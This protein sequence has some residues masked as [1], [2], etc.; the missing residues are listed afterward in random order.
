MYSIHLKNTNFFFELRLRYEGGG[1]DNWN[2]AWKMVKVLGQQNVML[3]KA[4]F[5]TQFY[6]I[7]DSRLV[8]SLRQHRHARKKY[9]LEFLAIIFEHI[10]T[11]QM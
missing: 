11:K 9:V 6:Y 5:S 1:Y 4:S 3:A 8:W 2:E 7:C 10:Q